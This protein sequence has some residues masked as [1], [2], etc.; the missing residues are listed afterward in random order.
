MSLLLACDVST[1][2][3]SPTTPPAPATDVPATA[4]P[5]STWLQLYFT[6]PSA[7]ASKNHEGGPDAALA[8]AIDAARLSVDVAAYSFNLWSMR[9]A[10]IH[11]EQRGVV[12]RMVMESDNMDAPEEQELKDA[13]IPILGDQQESLMH[14]KFLIIDR[15]QV[16][17]GSMN[18][19]LGGTYDDNN[20]LICITSPQVAQDYTHEFEEM[21][22]DKRFGPDG[23]ADTPF[24][25]LTIADT[26][27]EIYFSPDDHAASR[28]VE[29]IQGARESIHFMAYSFTSN[30]IGNAIIQKAQEGL[31]VGGVMDESQATQQ[32]NEYDPFKQANLDVRL[33]GNANGLM[34]DKVII[35]DARYVIT[36][37]YNFTASAEDKNDENLVIIDNI[38]VANVYF[39]EFKKVYAEA[40]P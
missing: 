13:G 24:P 19:T 7:P 5:Y 36:G 26:P 18:F 9:D 37:S 16:W 23:T 2:A 22:V 27:V 14:D 15:S 3:P 10:L 17:T 31:A 1:L 28:I 29:L 8:K 30:D 35:I 21:F 33:D 6:S 32:G 11:A 34:H 40:Q 25:S 39:Q 20:N 4:A 38:D 12:V